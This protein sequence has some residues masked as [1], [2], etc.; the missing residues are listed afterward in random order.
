MK[1]P[2]SNTPGKIPFSF[3]PRLWEGK[4]GCLLG[5][6]AL[7]CAAKRAVVWLEKVSII[8]VFLGHVCTHATLQRCESGARTCD[9]DNILLIYKTAK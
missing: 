3:Q 7:F 4:F 9:K 6:E 2:K 1:T 8:K 5:K